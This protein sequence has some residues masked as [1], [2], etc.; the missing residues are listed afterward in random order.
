LNHSLDEYDDKRSFGLQ[1]LF[2]SPDYEGDNN[3]TVPVSPA[4]SPFTPYSTPKKA[5]RS[6]PATPTEEYT[7]PQTPYISSPTRTEDPGSITPKAASVH[8]ESEVAKKFPGGVQIENQAD[9]DHWTKLI[10]EEG[11]QAAFQASL[12]AIGLQKDEPRKAKKVKDATTALRYALE[13]LGKANGF[14]KNV[15]AYRGAKFSLV[16]LEK[17]ANASIRKT[18]RKREAKLGKVKGE[19]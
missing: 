15:D 11:Y 7:I 9:L 3:D 16:R 1:R 12:L 17:L 14:D 8:A 5:Q 19:K 10:K 4:T 13:R 6:L 18:N 2:G